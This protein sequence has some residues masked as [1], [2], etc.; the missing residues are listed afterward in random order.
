[1]RSLTIQISGMHCEHCTAAVRA[2]LA[3]IDGLTVRTIELESHSAT[4]DWDGAGNPVHPIANAL[5]QAGYRL[6]GFEWGGP[7][8]G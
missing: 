3:A 4:L 5:Q 2:A 8:G 1:M 7:A 6:G